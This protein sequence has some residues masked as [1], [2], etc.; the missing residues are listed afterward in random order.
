M[1]NVQVTIQIGDPNVGMEYQTMASK[2]LAAAITDYNATY[3]DEDFIA[4]TMVVVVPVEYI[5]PFRA[6]V[7]RMGF[8]TTRR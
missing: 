7:E 2:F 8:L 3:R 4:G 6:F 5:E 1:R